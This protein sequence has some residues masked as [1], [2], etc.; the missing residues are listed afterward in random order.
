MA[1]SYKKKKLNPSYSIETLKEAVK[2]VKNKEL[3]QRAAAEKY[4]IPKSVIQ[5][6][7]S[8]KVS[9]DQQGPGRPK[10]LT[11]EEE[12]HIVECILARAQAGYPCDRMELLDLV[13]EYVRANNIKN[14]F[15]EGRPGEDWYLGFMKRNSSLSLKKAELLQAQRKKN[16]APDIVY[17]F[18]EK[19]EKVYKDK[20]LDDTSKACFIFNTDESGFG[21][22][23]TRLKAIGKKGEPLSRVSGG[24]GRE[25]K[26]V[27][28]CTSANGERLPPLIVFKGAAVQARW[29]SEKAYIGTQYAVSASGWMEIPLFLNWFRTCFIPHVK[30]VREEKGLPLQEAVLIFDGHTSHVTLDICKLALENRITLIRLPSHLTDKLQPLDKCLWSSENH[31]G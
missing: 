14:N 29:V 23:P 26:T 19:L 6:R 11:N 1:R 13:G 12:E 3:S 9:A 18:Y 30:R 28:A 22:D 21:T 24:S 10:V 7:T 15:K 4:G 20:D 17:D 27:L 31:M 8:G 5:L 16:T 25:S 2:K